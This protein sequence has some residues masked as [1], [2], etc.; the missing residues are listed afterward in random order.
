[1]KLKLALLTY[2]LYQNPSLFIKLILNLPWLI[3]LVKKMTFQISHPLVLL[4]DTIFTQ[5]LRIHRRSKLFQVAGLDDE[6][7]SKEI[8]SL[9]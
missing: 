1:M 5:V 7:R 2:L 4:G 8:I 3:P 6:D 9:D